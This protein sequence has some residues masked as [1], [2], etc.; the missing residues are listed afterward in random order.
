VPNLYPNVALALDTTRYVFAPLGMKNNISSAP[1][2]NNLMNRKP[3]II[4]I[5]YIKKYKQCPILLS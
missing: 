5:T 4:D 2:C 1:N 3:T